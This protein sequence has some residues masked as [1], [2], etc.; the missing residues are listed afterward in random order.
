MSESRKASV[1]YEDTE[2]GDFARFVKYAYRHDYM[3]PSLMRDESVAE[4]GGKD[5]LPSSPIPPPILFSDP[6]FD[7]NKWWFEQIA[8]T[9]NAS[10]SPYDRKSERRTPQSETL[11][12]R[13][14]NR[15]YLLD[16][17]PKAEMLEGFLHQAIS[18]PG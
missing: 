3:V 2:P 9:R 6:D 5:S 15:D 10:T 13:L 7:I 11:E 4:A 8:V 17:D 12:H 1:E 16:H 18:A 14:R